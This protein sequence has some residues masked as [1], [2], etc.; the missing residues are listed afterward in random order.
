M[1]DVLCL[2]ETWL[3][4]D[5]SK[6]FKLHNYSKIAEYSRENTI[7]GGVAIIVCEGAKIKASPIGKLNTMSFEQVFECCGAIISHRACKFILLCIYR[8]PFIDHSNFLHFIELLEDALSMIKNC[9]DMFII[10]NGD[11][12]VDNLQS[13]WERECLYDVLNSY[14]LCFLVSANKNNRC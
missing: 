1:P 6:H 8:P 7:G 12:N 5:K 14:A 4:K 9:Y 10:I 11:F 3:S 13:S 2:A